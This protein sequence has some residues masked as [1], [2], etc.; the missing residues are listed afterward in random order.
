MSPMPSTPR[1]P[2]RDAARRLP[3][4][5]RLQLLAISGVIAV[6]AIGF[7]VSPAGATPPQPPHGD[8]VHP[9]GG[10]DHLDNSGH[11]LHQVPPPS[12]PETPPPPT[13]APTSG[14]VAG[15]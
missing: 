15:S 8:G 1:A 2:G 3:L 14:G 6:G 10:N 11:G 12:P 9:G 7:W 4:R 13:Q 5:A